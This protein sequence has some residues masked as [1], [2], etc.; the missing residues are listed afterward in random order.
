MGKLEDC[1]LFHTQPH[2]DTVT[3]VSRRWCSRATSTARRWRGEGGV[4]TPCSTASHP[5]RHW[6][7][8]HRALHPQS[9]LCIHVYAVDHNECRPTVSILIHVRDCQVSRPWTPPT[10]DI[11]TRVGERGTDAH[12]HH[13]HRNGSVQRGASECAARVIL[14][15]TAKLPPLPSHADGRAA[16]T[17]HRAMALSCM[18][19]SVGSSYCARMTA[20]SPGDKCNRNVSRSPVLIGNRAPRSSMRWVMRKSRLVTPPSPLAACLY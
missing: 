4:L 10:K 7:A 3:A 19:L 17:H 2:P 6:P 5:V 9:K 14:P 11:H 20:A 16:P 15:R 8:A 12:T 1:V 18:G 13:T